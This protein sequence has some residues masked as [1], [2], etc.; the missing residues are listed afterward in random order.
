MAVLGSGTIGLLALTA[1]R[2]A[3]A[4]QEIVSTDPL[5]GQAGPGPG[6]GGRRRRRRHA[7]PTW[8][9][10]VRAELGE[11]VDVVFDCVAHQ[12]TV[13]AAIK[14]AL[15][16]GT[17]VV[18]GG[19]RRPPPSTCPCSRST[20]SASRGR[21]P[22]A[23]RT[24][25]TPSRSSV[26]DLRR[27]PFHNRHLPP[28]RGGRGLRRHLVGQRGEDPGGKRQ[29]PGLADVGAQP[30]G[31]VASPVPTGL[32]S[33]PAQGNTTLTEGQAGPR[34][35]PRGTREGRRK[36]EPSEKQGRGATKKGT[37]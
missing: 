32:A 25:T 33:L 34:R 17:V 29:S 26:R 21:P 28:R 22:T 31:P 23:G 6:P 11:S 4:G 16:G 14:M 27:R 2:H 13:E 37:K 9:R 36:T 19:A 8:S 7:T 30:L 20:R 24:S 5:A 1:A 10:L 35:R 18:V 15:K 12:A 3:G